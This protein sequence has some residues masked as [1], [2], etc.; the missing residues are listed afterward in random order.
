[1]NA[2]VAGRAKAAGAKIIR[3]LDVVKRYGDFTALLGVSLLIWLIVGFW[4]WRTRIRVP[5]LSARQDREARERRARRD[6]FADA[7]DD[8]S[9]WWERV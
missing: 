2:P 3:Y 7:T 6:L 5:R 9:F 1:M 4:W 8:E